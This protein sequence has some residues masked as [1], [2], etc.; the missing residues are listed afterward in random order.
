MTHFVK[1]IY[2][3][4]LNRFRGA[5]KV[6]SLQLLILIVCMCFFS[7]LILFAEIICSVGCSEAYGDGTATY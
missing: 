3:I 6:R 4:E 5:P 7:V 1:L 2:F